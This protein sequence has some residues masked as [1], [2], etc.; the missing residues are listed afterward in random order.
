[1]NVV[2]RDVSQI[3]LKSR[4]FQQGQIVLEASNKAL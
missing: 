3:I 2:H 1:M 4:Y